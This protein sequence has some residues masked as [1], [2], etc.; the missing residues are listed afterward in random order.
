MKILLMMFLCIPL[1][2]KTPMQISR[3][4]EKEIM[5]DGRDMRSLKK[6]IDQGMEQAILRATNA[7][8]D[9]GRFD[10]ANEVWGDWLS[11]NRTMF[12]MRDQGDHEP[13]VKKINELYF[14]V[15]FILGRE[16]CVNTHISAILTFNSANVVVRP[17]TF[18][19]DNVQGERVDE[20]LKHFAGRSIFVDSYYNGLLPEVVYFATLIGCSASGAV[21]L[22]GLAASAA[23]KITATL[24]APKLGQYIYK[25]F[26]K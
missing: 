3:E 17:C 23:D 21:P 8:V 2:A 22:C 11:L 13:I 7:L 16:F 5:A 14:K 12:P 1:F 24:I 20:Y 26:C 18:P 10:V 6:Y 25:R 19:M 4:I 15:E 9:R